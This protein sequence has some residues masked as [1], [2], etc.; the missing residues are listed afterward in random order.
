LI[1][2][3]DSD[4][5]LGNV[6]GLVGYST[7]SIEN[8]YAAVSLKAGALELVGGLAAENSGTISDSYATGSVKGGGRSVVGGLIGTPHA[9]SIIT[10][11]HATGK[12]AS[13]RETVAGGLVGINYGT[14][15][16]SFATGSVAAGRGSTSG[17][18]AGAL[19]SGSVFES[20]ARGDSSVE[21]GDTN[22]K[23]GVGGFAGY[24]ASQV[25]QSYSTGMP[26]AGKRSVSGGFFGADK[27][28]RG[29][30]ADAY[31]D[32]T[33]SGTNVGVGNR[34]RDPGITGLTTQQFQSG[35]PAG[36]S[37]TVWKEKSKI[38]NG[39]PYLID[40]SPPQ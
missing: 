36:F 37:P 17:G 21:S 8:S 12:V 24:N 19:V 3:G 16:Q 33:T 4:F 1:E 40:N 2:A 10:G 18:F 32:T 6:G 31:W 14:I 23:S 11:C 13:G 35:L 34:N 28:S 5:G 27:S 20:Y 29:S 39:F 7:G 9:S 30:I 15:S 25:S 26:S 38:N 22:F